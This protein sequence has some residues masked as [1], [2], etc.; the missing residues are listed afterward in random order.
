MFLRVWLTKYGIAYEI[1][2][3]TYDNQ[4]LS[5]TKYLSQF[6]FIPEQLQNKYSQL[7]L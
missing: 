2:L 6:L 1:C 4:L 3:G 7:P 5:Y